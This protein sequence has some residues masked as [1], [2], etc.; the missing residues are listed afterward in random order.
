MSEFTVR[1]ARTADVRGIHRMLEPYVQR[2]ILL[3]KDIVVLYEAVQQF[4]V[5]EDAD[6]RLIG[7]GALHVMWD[8][9]GEIRTLIV[10]DGWLHRGVGRGLVEALEQSARTLGIE[11]LFCLTF[12]VD[13]F[14]RRG[15]APIGEHVVDPDVY[16]QLVRSPD[17]GIAEFLDLAHVK[18][19][20]LGNTRMLKRL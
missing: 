1:P 15:F 8:D 14:T 18:P 10:D 7:C 17:E 12:E 16:S 9:L 2:R 11:R 5:A 3:G 13:F 4:V 20:T 19:N 6:G